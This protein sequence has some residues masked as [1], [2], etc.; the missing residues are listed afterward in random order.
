MAFAV[1]AKSALMNELNAELEGKGLFV[2]EIYSLVMAFM[3]KLK[4]L[5]SQLEGKILTHANTAGSHTIRYV[6]LTIGYQCE[7][8]LC[9]V[10]LTLPKLRS[11]NIL[12]IKYNL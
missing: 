12:W 9:E 7:L 11:L 6:C 3:R 10:D 1:I 5:S 4:L 2:P 8:L